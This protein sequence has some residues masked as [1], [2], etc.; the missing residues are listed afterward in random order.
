MEK[1][2]GRVGTFTGSAATH[3]SFQRTTGCTG[4]RYTVTRY[5]VTR[6]T[7]ARCKHNEF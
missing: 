5:P 2:S 4:A 6:D 3:A 1:R 7:S